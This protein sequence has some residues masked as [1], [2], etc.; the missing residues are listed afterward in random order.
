MPPPAPIRLEV[1]YSETANLAYQLDVV[2]ERLPHVAPETLR[3]LWEARFLR[4][5]A[6][7]AALKEWGELKARYNGWAPFPSVPMPLSPRNEGISLDDVVRTAELRATSIDAFA[8]NLGVIA[9]MGDVARFRKV[10]EHFQP[11]FHEWWKGEPAGQGSHFVRRMRSLI[12]KR[13]TA[14]A[15]ERFRRF[16]DAQIPPGMIARFSLIYRPAGP[17]STNGQQLGDTAAVEFRAGERPESRIDVVLHEFCHFLF[18]NR[19]VGSD[20]ELQ[21]RFAD[22]GDPSAKPALSL[23][24]EG[25]ATALGN[26]IVVRSIVSADRW[27]R[28]LTTPRSFYN[29][30]AIDRTGK[31]LLKL[32]DTGLTLDRPEFVPAYLAEM[33][34]EFGDE[35]RRPRLMLN[36]AYVLVGTG[37]DPALGRQARR[38]LRMSSTSMYAGSELGDDDLREYRANPNLSALFLVS[39]GQLDTLVARGVLDAKD[40]E[41]IRAESAKGPVVYAR[42]HSAL[43]VTYFIVASDAA[44]VKGAVERLNA[45]SGA[46]EGVLRT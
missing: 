23:L 30:D 20:T 31:R 45:A 17:G 6:D 26:G 4:N 34:A 10:L 8:E 16:Y 27:N 41:A 40:A 12:A 25:L 21:K 38:T 14:D 29:D 44:G 24:N 36:E 19:A 42:P 11:A 15:V 39:P 43:A 1:V 35:L 33:K 5:D 32:I 7:R 13:S 37:L 28:Y 22:S 2:S 46:F 9:P 18:R 3:P